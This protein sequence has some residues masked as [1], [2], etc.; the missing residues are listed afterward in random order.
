MANARPERTNTAER[1]YSKGEAQRYDDNARMAAT[2][3]ALAD[4]A[5]SLLDLPPNVPALLLD[6]GCGTGYSGRPLEKAGHTWIGTDVSL[7]MLQAAVATVGRGG[8]RQVVCE[9]LGAGFA[10]GGGRTG[11]PFSLDLLPE[12]LPHPHAGATGEA[13][14]GR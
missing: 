13:L 2:Q 4:R 12:V 7:N 8:K 11:P 1:F 6:A 10:F 3:R 14:F 5:L 9:D